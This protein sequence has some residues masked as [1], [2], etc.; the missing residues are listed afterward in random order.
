MD[1]SHT[2]DRIAD[3]T[4]SQREA[5][6]VILKKKH[7]IGP[8]RLTAFVTQKNSSDHPSS[9]ELQK[10]LSSHLPQYMVPKDYHVLEKLPLTSNGKVDRKALAESAK[11]DPRTKTVVDT[12]SSQES[13]PLKSIWEKAF[14]KKIED[15]DDFFELGGDSIMAMQIVSHA[16]SAGI[17]LRVTDLFRHSRFNSLS[18]TLNLSSAQQEKAEQPTAIVSIFRDVLGV[19]DFQADDDF[20][21]AGGDSI[22]AISLISKLRERGFSF[23]VSSLFKH[24]S[25]N[26]L[27]ASISAGN[28]AQVAIPVGIEATLSNSETSHLPLTPI[29]EWFLDQDLDSPDHWNQS[30]LLKIDK[31]R[32]EETIRNAVQSLL[33]R[34]ASLRL[35][36]CEDKKHQSIRTYSVTNDIVETVDAR[37][38]EKNVL[39]K[40]IQTTADKLHPQL[41][42]SE[43][44][45]LRGAIFQTD[46]ETLLLLAV[47][48]WSVDAVSWTRLLSDLESQLSN[49]STPSELNAV[50]DSELKEVL[51]NIPNRANRALAA[52]AEFWTRQDYAKCPKL[53]SG[54]SLK[55]READT[56]SLSFRLGK[57]ET[58]AVQNF[59]SKHYSSVQSALLAAVSKS[60]VGF[61]G[62]PNVLIGVE[63]HG[64]DLE[65]P[66]TSS[67]V[68]WMTSYFPLVLDLSH[69]EGIQDCLNDV[70]FQ[71]DRIPAKGENFGLIRT[72]LNTREGG[73]RIPEP[74]ITFNYLGR[75]SETKGNGTLEIVGQNIGENRDPQNRRTAQFE[76][77]AAIR[78]DEL[79]V[80]W[81]FNPMLHPNKSMDALLVEVRSHFLS[82]SSMGEYRESG[83]ELR[84]EISD[85][86]QSLLLH[87][88]GNPR[89]DQGELNLS[90]EFVGS[91]NSLDLEQAWKTVFS[92][93]PALRSRLS[94]T[95]GQRPV[96]IIGPTS[97]AEITPLDLTD[98]EQS[99]QQQ[100]LS[101]TK[102]DFFSQ[103]LDLEHGPTQ[104]LLLVNTAKD[105]HHFFWKCH[106]LFIDGWSSSIILQEVLRLANGA[107]ISKTEEA[108]E[109]FSEYQR[110]ISS[111]SKASASAFWKDYLSNCSPCN[112]GTTTT[113]GN[114]SLQKIDVGAEQLQAIKSTA[115]EFRSTPSA[116]LTAAWA[117]TLS[118]LS[119]SSSVVFGYTISG[120][121]IEI[122]NPQ[123]VV[124]NLASTVPIRIDVDPREN[125]QFWV[126]SVLK[127]QEMVSRFAYL[128]S[129]RILGSLENV[130]LNLFDT[131]LTIAN[132]P[133]VEES[134]KV[135]LENFKGDST[136][137]SPL[138]LSIE[139]ADILKLNFDFDTG[140][141]SK[142]EVEH[143]RLTFQ[144]AV[145]KLITL[146]RRS[147]SLYLPQ[148][149]SE[150]L[151][152]TQPGTSATPASKSIKNPP[153]IGSSGKAD[154]LNPTAR[155]ASIFE[156]ILDVRSCHGTDDFFELGGTSL[157][158]VRLFRKIEDEF[159]KRLA[160]S[161]LF[162]NSTVTAIASLLGADAP[163]L[164]SLKNLVTIRKGGDSVPLFLIHAGGLQVLFYRELAN[165][166]DANRTIYGLQ[167]IGRD[168]S[169]PPC[170]SIQEIATRHL[171]EV[172]AVYSNGP[173]ILV[174]HCFGA[175]VAIE[176]AKQLE[177]KGKQV[178]LIVSIDGESPHLI[179]D[180]VNEE[181]NI[182][183][184]QN[185]FENYPR[186]LRAPRRMVRNARRLIRR[187][188]ESSRRY[189]SDSYRQNAELTEL[190]ESSVKIAFR[191]HRTS[192]Y[193]GP[194]LAFRCND[195]D[196][197]ANHG[198]ADWQRVAPNSEMIQVECKHAE[199]LKAPHAA[200]LADSINEKLKSF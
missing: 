63:G 14:G 106:H 57:R 153:A 79:E 33:A 132:Y 139:L 69:S 135:R 198:K 47:H 10:I 41:S 8:H 84:Y 136:S 90:G 93:H 155:V 72:R 101:R 131:T 117:L 42:L 134:G 171:S 81:S 194:V 169:E 64:R 200:I 189:L 68:S 176:M 1:K 21:E 180:E 12:K 159:G 15:D 130:S 92:T 185:S 122:S 151:S 89:D 9:K 19:P 35:A 111:R 66:N 26:K 187:L 2:S 28:Q 67:V 162:T 29:Q 186:L 73:S 116:I 30:V 164:P 54:I 105:R 195:S 179:G 71:L 6:L 45:L 112:I 183:R 133:W 148:V 7:P 109:A 74:E 94:E 165:K 192:P 114:R 95:K 110:W 178:P 5:L 129:A 157:Q 34:H 125:L 32:T 120:R 188:R 113:A 156:S 127:N 18:E 58:K 20:F 75:Q 37:G 107:E 146:R 193:R 48:H 40:L 61:I 141:F 65:D 143:I 144:E 86:Q 80:N 22:T 147:V 175:A 78:D 138:S 31:Q 60:L 161:V 174:G 199:I 99:D 173:Y 3:L 197:Y 39:D 98:L 166:L 160:P 140:A 102:E 17:E 170:K 196:I 83:E 115:K 128:S 4:P 70:Q 59:A 182:P 13:N 181:D 108:N 88:L 158:A 118:A 97:Q 91:P 27:K 24:P 137:L 103:S 25:P 142:S 16:R 82:L 53:H 46:R 77:N 172:E 96:Q 52:E 150:F 85:I 51:S 100:E 56:A 152:E 11:K 49:P 38:L 167:S 121:D 36:L 104:R 87:R 177:A 191:N 163:Q 184:Y 76:I 168:G 190:M 44:P 149:S 126:Q 55:N 119:N 43:G 145:D 62:S 123:A 50:G 154:S 23:S 124:A